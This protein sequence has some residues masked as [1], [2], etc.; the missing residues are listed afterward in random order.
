MMQVEET[1]V[2]FHMPPTSVGNPFDG[3]QMQMSTG[4][5]DVWRLYSRCSSLHWVIGGC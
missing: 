3:L 1:S 4:S 2:Q 5:A